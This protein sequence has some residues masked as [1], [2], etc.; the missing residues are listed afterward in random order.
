M[1][2]TKS[3]TPPVE[4]DSPFPLTDEKALLRLYYEGSR[5]PSPTDGFLILLRVQPE[6]DGSG[7]I[8]F[9]CNSSSLRFRLDVP[10]ATRTERAKVKA[11]ID[12]D[13]EPKCPRHHGEQLLI[14]VKNDFLC[15]RCGVRYARHRTA[16]QEIGPS[17]PAV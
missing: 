15:P 7:S 8:L 2:K 9:E 5:L 3:E 11:M 4:G 14:R 6:G 12:D 13:R 10:K 1:S 17:G 16:R